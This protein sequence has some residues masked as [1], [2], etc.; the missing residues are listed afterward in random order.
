MEIEFDALL[1]TATFLSTP[2]VIEVMRCLADDQSPHWALPYA[3]PDLIDAAIQQL[4]DK[5]VARPATAAPAGP[6]GPAAP[7]ALTRK[8]TEILRLAS[9]LDWPIPAGENQY[10]VV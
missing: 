6:T 4:L 9:S 2:H 7:V 3:D 1:R 10:R 5:G 8:G